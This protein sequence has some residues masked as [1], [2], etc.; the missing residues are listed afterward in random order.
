MI[1]HEQFTKWSETSKNFYYIPALSRP[2][3]GDDWKGETGYINLAFERYFKGSLDADAYLA[4]SPIMVRESIKVLKAKG[5]KTE[6]IHRDPI[7]VK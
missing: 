7:R 1:L 6:R 5:I 3:E 4:G 2:Q